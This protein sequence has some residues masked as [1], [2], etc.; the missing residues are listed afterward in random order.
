MYKVNVSAPT[1]S[2]LMARIFRACP[3]L[4]YFGKRSKVDSVSTVYR[5]HVKAKFTVRRYVVRSVPAPSARDFGGL[6]LLKISVYAR[7]DSSNSRLHR[8]QSGSILLR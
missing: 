2:R 4:W 1:V 6:F 5:V 7:A 8:L 3:Y